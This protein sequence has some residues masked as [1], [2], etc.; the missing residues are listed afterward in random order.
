MIEG[1]ETITSDLTPYELQQ[2]LPLVRAGL[3]TKNGA[4]MAVTN[5]EIVAG[6]AKNCSI[7]ISE[8]RVR[9]I[10]NY[11]RVKNMIPRLIATSRGYYVA[12]SRQE[13]L[14]YI[15]SLRSREN[16]IKSVRLSI[17]SQLQSFH[18]E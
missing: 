11:I 9:K 15:E 7:S 2:V 12:E 4:A 18:F 16:A 17:E 5:K 10:I 14:D 1:F 13:V 6:L 8:P 3:L